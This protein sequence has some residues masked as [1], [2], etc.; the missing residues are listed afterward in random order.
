MRQEARAFIR[1]GRV[2]SATP[3]F[4]ATDL[5]HT[6]RPAVVSATG[7]SVCVWRVMR[8]KHTY[9]ARFCTNRWLVG[10]DRICHAVF[11]SVSAAVEVERSSALGAEIEAWRHARWKTCRDGVI[12]VVGCGVR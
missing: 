3:E 12:I 7:E 8:G 9:P 4:F 10:R 6:S 2:Q 1:N 5:R 11:A